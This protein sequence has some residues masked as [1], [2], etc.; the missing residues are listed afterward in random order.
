MR[1]VLVILFLYFCIARPIACANDGSSDLSMLSSII[2]VQNETR[3]EIW[4]HHK[5]ARAD[6]L[7]RRVR[8]IQVLN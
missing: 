1:V 3:K 5:L 2:C 4:L 6:K 7:V 8:T